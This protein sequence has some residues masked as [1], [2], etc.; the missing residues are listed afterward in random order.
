M[1]LPEHQPVPLPRWRAAAWVTLG[2]VVALL[3]VLLVAA[4]LT[5]ATQTN[6][7][8]STQQN[9]RDALTAIQDCTTPGKDCFER[10][11]KSTA[12][13]VATINKVAVYAAACADR[14]RQQSVEQISACV[15]ARLA[16]DERR[17]P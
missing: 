8:R 17:S 4:I 10:G 7:I 16:R 2:A 5:T 12:K 9:S 1:T 11:Q 15:F 14:P 6:A 13:A 3:V